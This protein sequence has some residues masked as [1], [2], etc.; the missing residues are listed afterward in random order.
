MSRPAMEIS[1]PT[2]V[3][4]EVQAIVSSLRAKDRD[5]IR[6]LPEEK[7]EMLHHT[8]GRALRNA[9]RSNAYPH[10]FTYCYDQ[11]DPQSRSFDSLSRIAIRL[12]WEHLRY[13][14]GITAE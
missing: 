11:E 7:L 14:A 10:L 4:Q 5:Y 9:L 2:S 12:I 13:P 8:L 1:E 3:Q 6:Q